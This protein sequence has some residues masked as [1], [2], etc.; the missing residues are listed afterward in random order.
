MKELEKTKRISISTVIFI[1][2]ILI[3]VLTF[4]KPTN[5]YEKTNSETLAMLN[6]RDYL[7]DYPDV[8]KS[9][10]IFMDVRDR[11]EYSKGHI[12]E[13]FNMPTADILEEQSIAMFDELRDAG[14]T[15]VFYGK[16]PNEANSAWMIMYQLGYENVK[17]LN[18]ST[19]LVDNRFQVT[20][21]SLEK[22]IA[23]YL[24]IFNNGTTESSE[25]KQISAPVTPKKVIAVK[26][27]KKRKP[28]GGC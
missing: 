14:K 16:N 10:S 26:K 5:V 4:K 11:F 22:P 20:N 12:D 8:D 7:V 13:A 15:V 9:N 3:G 28:E 18:N 19:Q 17:I 21:Y 23:N 24:E 27:K 2:V 6:T 1:L 25:D